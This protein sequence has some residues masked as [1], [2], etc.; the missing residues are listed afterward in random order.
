MIPTRADE[1]LLVFILLFCVWL[2][3]TSV[4]L[5]TKRMSFGGFFFSTYYTINHIK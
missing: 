1:C 2:Y 3:A 4:S 5:F